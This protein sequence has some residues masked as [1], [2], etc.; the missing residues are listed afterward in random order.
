MSAPPNKGRGK[1]FQWLHD[2]RAFAGDECLIWPYNRHPTGYGT[3]SYM[4]QIH[5]AHR[6]MCELVNGPA[7]SARHQAAHSCGQGHAGCV[8]PQHLSWKSISDNLLDRRAHG[9]VR[10]NTNGQAGTLSADQISQI[11]ALKGIVTQSELAVLFG[12]KRPAIQY[13]HK[14]NKPKAPAKILSDD[15]VREIRKLAGYVTCNK[16]A[17]MFGWDRKAIKRVLIGR[18]YPNVA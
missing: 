11:R 16:I 18:D 15:D 9:T 4:G 2:R 17:T 7:P 5:Y 10:S 13:W 1:G 14:H 8:H 6:F 3:L 12:V